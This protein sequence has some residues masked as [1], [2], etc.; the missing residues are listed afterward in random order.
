MQ[1]SDLT[2]HI[3]QPE[4]IEKLYRKN[5]REFTAIF[6]QAYPEISDR[7]VAEY[8]KARLEFDRSGTGVNDIFKKDFFYLLPVCLVA[9]LF[10]E[11]P[12]LFPALAEPF[13]FFLK[14]GA[15][16]II[17]GMVIY[18]LISDRT[19]RHRRALVAIGLIAVS[20]LYINLLPVPEENDAI[21]LACIFLPI[22]LWFIYGFVYT[23]F[24]IKDLS[25]RIEYIRDNG[26]LAVL[27]TIIL[28]AGGILA[29][30]SAGLFNTIG[31]KVETIIAKHIAIWGIVSAPVAAI[32]IMRNYPSVANKIAPVIARIFSP[33]ILA[34][35]VLFLGYIAIQHKNPYSDRNFLLV[36]NF[37]LMVVVAVILFSV[38]GSMHERSQRFNRIILSALVVVSIVI[39]CIALSAI[40]YRLGEYGFTP[41]RTAV[42][43]TNLIILGN[44]IIIASNLFKVNFKNN[45]LQKVEHSVATYLP[46]YFI[47]SII[48]VFLL[49]FIFGLTQS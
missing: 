25:R 43:G 1:K 47:W 7:K 38:A 35:M 46:V 49:P 33:L 27:I 15:I 26:D 6:M 4:E 24:Q 12:N 23:Q 34:I 19:F 48:V 29:A 44:L 11:I 22:F 3:D 9:C 41:N 16:I 10:A 32:F 36:F 28:I 20:A 45:T 30:L 14:N 2:D 42:L 8:W 39:D 13:T 21:S 17:L 31:I 40:I 5:P 18:T 37:M